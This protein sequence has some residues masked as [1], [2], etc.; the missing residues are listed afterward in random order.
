MLCKRRFFSQGLNQ[1]M[2]QQNSIKCIITYCYF[3]N[4]ASSFVTCPGFTWETVNFFSVSGTVLCFE[5]RMRMLITLMLIL[6]FAKSRATFCLWSCSANDKVH[7]K[8]PRE[9]F[10]GMGDVN[11]HKGYSTS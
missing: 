2:F 10:A 11:C 6:V 8:K 9:S 7:L 1:K 3:R 4:R 5:F